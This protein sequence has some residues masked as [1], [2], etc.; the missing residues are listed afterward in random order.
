MKYD[1]DLLF[2]AECRNEDLRTLTDYLTHDAKGEIR[3]AEQLTD[4]DAYLYNY[5]HN[6]RN[7]WREI[8][9]ELQRYG[10]NTIVNCFRKHGVSY[11]VIVRDVC[12]KMR[13]AYS[14]QDTIEALEE[15][16]LR[17]M[18]ADAIERMNTKELGELVEALDIPVKDL[19]KQCVM[20]S[21]QLL[22]RKGGGVVASRIAMFTANMFSRMMLGHGL[23]VFGGNALGKVAG[24]FSGPL[25]WAL[26]AGWAAYDLSAPAYRVTIP[27]VIQI[28]YMRSVYN[29]SSW[30]VL[31]A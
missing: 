21:L 24:V 1:K 6:M 29:Q 30:K 31:T 8:A 26:T 18:L 9:N 3:M 4:T 5:P 15:R 16:L 12:K 22:L 27:C 19:R 17:K 11:R 10:G 28:A 20:A 13:M 25:G 23:W 2:L 7:M 14:E